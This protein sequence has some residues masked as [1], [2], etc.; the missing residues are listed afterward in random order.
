MFDAAPEPPVAKLITGMPAEEAAA[1]LPR[2]FNLCRAAQGAAARLA[3]GLE[4]DGAALA[5]SLTEEIARE[6]R[7]FL[8]VILPAR[9]NLAPLSMA[10]FPESPAAFDAFLS[11]DHGLAPLFSKIEALFGAAGA[12]HPPD[13]PPGSVP[14]SGAWENSAALRRRADPVMEHIEARY[15]RGPLWRLAGRAIDFRHCL[16]GNLPAPALPEPGFAIT[17]AARGV[18]AIRAITMAGRVTAFSR[19][20]PTDHMLAEGGVISRSL[21]A[22]PAERR[23]LAPLLIAVL[24]PCRN[25]MLKEAAHA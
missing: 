13:L 19:V 9:L 3:F 7:A 15:G 20:T 17:P 6:H 2:I 4:S 18:Y 24:D 1:M 16:S 11:S 8:T 10:R 21:A 12:A 14:A 5:A 25:V 23:N 22:L